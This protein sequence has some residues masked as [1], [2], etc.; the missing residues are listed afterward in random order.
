MTPGAS[1]GRGD[2]HRTGDHNVAALHEAIATAVPQRECIVAPARAAVGAGGMARAADGSAGTYRR[3]TWREVTDRT[4]GLAGA[5]AAAG[6]GRRRDPDPAVGDPWESPHDHVALYLHNG[7]EY[8]EGM[9]GAWKAGCAAVNVNY[10]YV[11]AELAYVLRDSAAVAVIYHASL[12]PTLAEALSE[13]PGIRLLLEVDDGSAT[14]GSTSGAVDYEKALVQAEPLTPSGLSADDRY[15][16]YTGGTTGAPKGVLWRQGDF[17]ATCL[18]VAGTADD[19]VRVAQRRDALRALP[20]APLMHGAAHW[21]AISCFVSGGTVVMPRDPTRFDP[22]DVL[23]TCERERVTALQIVGDPFAR[24]L[25]EEM[26]AR[27]YDLSSLRFLLSGGAVLSASTKARLRERLPELRIV[28]VLGSSETGRQ[29]VG[30]DRST[31]SPGPHA[32]VLSADRRGRLAPGDGEI[33]WLAQAGRVPLGYLG[34]PARTAATFPVIDGVRHAVA[35]DRVR[36]L[37]DGTVEFLGRDAVT[38]NT[39]GEKVFAEEVEA[40]LTA[41][42]A[43][44][45][46]IVTSRPSERWGQEIVAVLA[47]RRRSEAPPDEELRA[48]C[49]GRLAGYKVPKAFRWV[50]RV[51]RSPAGKPDYAWA[52][53][54]AADGPSS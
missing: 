42:P 17:L 2:A 11:A 20:A 35:G 4:R 47:A 38:I 51:R 19:L 49:R 12:A 45:D 5:L 33:G 7:P 30:G 36:L 15:I 1:A 28:D 23:A 24:P 3:L 6:L 43:V 26:D 13:L 10:H 50:D 37:A 54:V 40:A 34:D 31:F 27:R 32:A 21:N 9:L 39:G 52:R 48:H 14:S 8:L 29:A 18:G 22:A 44:A 41:H 16:L 53:T 25:L 46:A